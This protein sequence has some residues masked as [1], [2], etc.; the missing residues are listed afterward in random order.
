[1]GEGRPSSVGVSYCYPCAWPMLA[2]PRLSLA[3]ILPFRLS[4]TTLFLVQDAGC[5]LH[6]LRPSLGTDPLLVPTC[7]PARGVLS[8]H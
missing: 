6:L 1:M 3:S 4:P 7:L 8:F 2:A 5:I